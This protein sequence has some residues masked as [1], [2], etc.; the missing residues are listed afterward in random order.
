MKKR[1][2]SVRKVPLVAFWYPSQE[3]P[4]LNSLRPKGLRPVF[5]S[6]LVATGGKMLPGRPPG[7]EADELP[8]RLSAA[9]GVVL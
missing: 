8:R 5:G 2:F 1:H 4:I 6:H 9:D 3:L 7:L